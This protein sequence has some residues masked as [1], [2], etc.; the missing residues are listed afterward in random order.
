MSALTEAEIREVI[1]RRVAGYPN[2]DPTAKLREAVASFGDFLDN[3]AYD[4]LRSPDP[5]DQSRDH[6]EDIWSNDLR[7]SEAARL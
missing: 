5:R 6:P 1:G 3:P 2:D 4:V 7:R